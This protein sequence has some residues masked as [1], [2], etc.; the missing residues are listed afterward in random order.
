MFEEN[1]T[2]PLIIYDIEST[3]LNPRHDRIVELGALKI[4]PNGQREEFQQRLNPAR[5]IPKQVTELHGISDQDVADSPKFEDGAGKLK[6]FLRDAELA[7]FGI[8]QFDIPMLRAEFARVGV[9]FPAKDCRIIDAKT[10]FHK[11]EPRDLSAAYQFF[12]G[13]QHTDAHG[14]MPDVL[15][16][17]EVLKGELAKYNELPRDISKLHEFCNP[18][19]PDAI[20]PKGR[21]RWQE[22]EVVIG[23]GKKAGLTLKEIARKE[24]DYLR[25][26]IRKDFSPQA[27]AVAQAALEGRFPEKR[28]GGT[29]N[30]NS[31]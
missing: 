20:D 4:F 2:R 8:Q 7:G 29:E 1:L 9:D 26:M 21:F 13:K 23:F 19:D 28:S 18:E 5:K 31:E 11:K 17:Y 14:A 3:G 27:K 16:T 10:I 6:A 25:W 22:E 12:C 24:P 15:A 30:G